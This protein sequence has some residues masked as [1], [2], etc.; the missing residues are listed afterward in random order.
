MLPGQAG[1]MVFLHAAPAFGRAFFCLEE[2]N[3]IPGLT[4]LFPIILRFKVEPATLRLVD[5]CRPTLRF[6]LS[7]LRL[8]QHRLERHLFEAAKQVVPCQFAAAQLG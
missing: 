5:S 7:L 3:T 4:P 1:I 8:A 6:S 2:T